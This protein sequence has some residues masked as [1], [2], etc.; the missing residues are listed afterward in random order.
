MRRTPHD[1]SHRNLAV[2]LRV[3]RI[4]HVVLAEFAGAPA[5]DV[6]VLVVERKVDV[7][8]E[9]RDCPKAFQHGRQQFRIGRLRGN[10]DHFSDLPLRVLSATVLVPEPDR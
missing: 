2:Q 9:R 5:R 7:G 6:E 10:L 4:A 3:E 1:A 8:D